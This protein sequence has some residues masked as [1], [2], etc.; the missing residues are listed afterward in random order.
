[1]TLAQFTTA[2]LIADGDDDR[3][4]ELLEEMEE[5]EREDEE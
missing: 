1:M 5:S 2:G 3:E 4:L